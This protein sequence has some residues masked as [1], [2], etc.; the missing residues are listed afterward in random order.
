MAWSQDN[1][2]SLVAAA[3]QPAP[4]V[5]SFFVSYALGNERQHI[6]YKDK[7]GHLHELLYSNNE[8]TL[9]VTGWNR[10]NHMPMQ[11]IQ[12][13][14]P[15]PSRGSNYQGPVFNLLAARKGNSMKILSPR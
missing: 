7:L 2:F 6:I 8:W 9:Y 1:L 12:K 5:D 14:P 13:G 11:H 3:R 15:H 4:P 10:V